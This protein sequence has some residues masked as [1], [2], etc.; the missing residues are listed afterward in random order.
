MN[1]ILKDLFIDPSQAEFE[2][3]DCFKDP[4]GLHEAAQIAEKVA[5]QADR[6]KRILRKTVVKSAQLEESGDEGQ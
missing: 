4:V 3:N 2:G 5:A 1:E 6:E